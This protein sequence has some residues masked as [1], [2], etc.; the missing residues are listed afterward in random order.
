VKRFACAVLLIARAAGC[1]HQIYREKRFLH[2]PRRPTSFARRYKGGDENEVVEENSE[3]GCLDRYR[4][5]S[6]EESFERLSD[7]QVDQECLKVNRSCTA[8]GRPYELRR[9]EE[10]IETYRD[11]LAER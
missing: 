7:L 2:R 9:L 4:E 5:Y 8:Y 1:S 3:T 6:L 11:L 10:R